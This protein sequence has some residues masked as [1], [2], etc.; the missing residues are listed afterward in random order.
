VSYE[1][2]ATVSIQNRVLSLADNLIYDV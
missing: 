2:I 1:E